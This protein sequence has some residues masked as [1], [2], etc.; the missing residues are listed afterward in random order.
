MTSP[1]KDLRAS[2]EIR[3]ETNPGRFLELQREFY[4]GD[5]NFVPPLAAGEKWQLQPH[6]NPFFQHAEVGLFTAWR[7]GTLVGRVSACRDRLNDEFHGDRVGFFGHFEARDAA[8][9]EQLVAH[10]A[11]WCRQ[12]GATE[13]RGPIDL[14][15]NYR[16]GLLI[17]GDPGTPVMMMPYNPPQYADWLTAAGLQKAK[18]LVAL[19]GTKE[20]IDRKRM[21]RIAEHLQKRNAARLRQVD[22]RRFTEDVRTMWRLYESIW[23]RNWGFTPMPEAEFLAQARDLKK[24]AHPALLQI[25]EVEGKPVGFLVALPD[26]NKAVHACNGR[27]L[28]FGW[29]KFLRTLR[30]T[31][32]IRVLTM[33]VAREYRRAG[34]DVMMMQRVMEDGIAAGFDA[35]EASWILE[36]NDD[37]LSPLATMGLRLYR[38]Y[39]IY[40]KSLR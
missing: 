27:L 24:I 11:A 16:C 25:A 38:R 39:R 35:C 32:S 29:W 17:E 19:A 26:V 33:G 23:D 8:A 18:D 6:R 14:S 12:R 13:L 10:A 21:A 37:M 5:R 4:R 36:D 30:A 22:M 34:V 31:R 2:V 15:T 20:G 3:T 9:A 28:P 7:E 1:A 40:S